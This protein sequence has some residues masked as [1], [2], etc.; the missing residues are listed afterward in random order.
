MCVDLR[1]AIKV[2][3][4]LALLTQ[5]A[6]MILQIGL[7]VVGIVRI[8]KYVFD[9]CGYLDLLFFVFFAIPSWDLYFGVNNFGHQYVDFDV[10]VSQNTVMYYI[11]V[12]TMVA[13][14]F[15]F[16]YS[17]GAK[18][19][20]NKAGEG[21]NRLV[22][23]QAGAKCDVLIYLLIIL[24][25][26]LLWLYI[27]YTAYKQFGR[28][29]VLFLLPSRKSSNLSGVMGILQ[30]VIPALV[31]SL[32]VIRNWHNNSIILPSLIP[33]LMLLIAASSNNTRREIIHAI[34]FCG[35]L[36]LLKVFKN[37]REKKGK[38]I[39][40]K[41]KPWYK[42]IIV[43]IAMVAFLV[44]LL[45]YLRSYSTQLARGVVSVNPFS[46]HS[47]SDLLFGSSSTGFDTTLVVDAYDKTYGGLFLHLIRFYLAFWIPRSINPNKLMQITQMVK[48][49]RGDW[50]NLSLFYINDLYFSFKAL[51]ILFVPL[52]GMLISVIYNK[53]SRS[54]KI[55]KV[56]FSSY[57]FSQILLLFKNGVSVYLVRITLFGVML[58]FVD[59]VSIHVRMRT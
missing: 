39:I 26:V 32:S 15:D 17:L 16:G 37:Q 7:L 52:I 47:F 54:G 9:L 19:I 6:L 49:A 40:L 21:N 27:M 43:G 38:M 48:A 24:P 57:M 44:P 11:A 33:A 8:K 12:T 20:S 42:F 30:L 18:I 36:F 50:G 35:L 41:K 22:D 2:I 28:S 45:W 5:L 25:L 29:L 1:F 56:V 46:L 4:L 59:W 34:M 13:V 53:T 55:A 31:F 23:T 3:T 10:T 51:S 14:L 58:L